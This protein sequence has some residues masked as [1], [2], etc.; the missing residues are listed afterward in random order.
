MNLVRG[1]IELNRHCSHGFDEIF[2]PRKY[3]VDGNRDFI[4]EFAKKYLEPGLTVF[5]V[6]GGKQPYIDRKTKENFALR[7]VGLDIDANELARAPQGLYDEVICADITKFVGTG[8]A[9]LLVCQALLEHVSDVSAAFRSFASILKPGGRAV[10]FVPSRNAVFAR[11]NLLLPEGFKRWMLFKIFPQAKVGAGFPSF[12]DRCTP[13]E[14]RELLR[15]N[16]LREIEFRP[17]FE[18]AY[19]SFF[20]PGHILWRLW[21]Q[22]FRL[23]K[24]DQAAET[25]CLAFVREA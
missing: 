12:Y 24:G 23:M 19:F 14:F 18:S 2:V 21:T 13:L 4:D 3:R 11:L 8:T 15:L 10:V 6:G 16:S 7:I 1:F 17:Y 9:D 20:F 5:D 25:F 22:L